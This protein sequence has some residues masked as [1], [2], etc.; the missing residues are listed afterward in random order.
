MP[1]LKGWPVF[2]A[3]V[4]HVTSKG[5][6]IKGE[7]EEHRVTQGWLQSYVQIGK[8]LNGV[9][10]YRNSGISCPKPPTY[11][12][13]NQTPYAISLM[14]TFASGDAQIATLPAKCEGILLLVDSGVLSP[15]IVKDGIINIPALTGEATI[16]GVLIT[17][18]QTPPI[19]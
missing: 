10:E 18:D 2:T 8:A 15:I 6:A 19:S 11:Q 9:W 5:V 12:N 3:S 4:E 14:A 16:S 13:L 17:L 7:G 1:T